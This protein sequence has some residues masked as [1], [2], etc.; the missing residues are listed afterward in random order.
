MLK[1]INAFLDKYKINL[2]KKK[3][4]V[5]FSGGSDSVALLSAFYECVSNIFN[6]LCWKEVLIQIKS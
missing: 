1:K 5:C 6:P 2:E 4:C 3:V